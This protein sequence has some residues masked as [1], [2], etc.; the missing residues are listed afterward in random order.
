M[1]YSAIG[2]SRCLP[3]PPIFNTPWNIGRML[4][5]AYPLPRHRSFNATTEAQPPSGES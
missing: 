3:H 5:T 4:E 2:I 1:L